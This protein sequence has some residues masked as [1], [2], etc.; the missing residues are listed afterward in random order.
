MTKY[1]KTGQVDVY[2]PVSGG[3]G[4]GGDA[5]SVVIGCLTFLGIVMFLAMLNGCN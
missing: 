4:G 5:E 2:S 1:R 3:G